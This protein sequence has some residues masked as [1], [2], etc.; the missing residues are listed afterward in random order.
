MKPCAHKDFVCWVDVGR[1]T[2][3]APEGVEAEDLDPH[4]FIAEVKV[5]CKECEEVF[6]FKGIDT[7]FDYDH[8]TQA[9]DGLKA[10]LPLRTPAE[11]AMAGPLAALDGDAR[12][13][14]RGVRLEVK[15]SEEGVESA[16]TDAVRQRTNGWL[17]AYR[18]GLAGG[19]DDTEAQ[20]Q[21]DTKME[22]EFGG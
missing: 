18:E 13:A 8:P 10:V 17:A 7:G 15:A 20:R 21:A 22:V 4:A 6:G 3:S 14:A 12:R 9:M 2:E 1:I 11:M 16:I 5:Q 19:L